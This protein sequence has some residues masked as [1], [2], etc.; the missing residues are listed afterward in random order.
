MSLDAFIEHLTNTH[1]LFDKSSYPENDNNRI[2]GLFDEE[3]ILGGFI[4]SLFPTLLIITFYMSQNKLNKIIIFFLVL[5]FCYI[6]IISGERSSFVK[7]LLLICGFI[8]FTSFFLAH[9]KKKLFF[10]YAQSL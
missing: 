3:Y 9:I 4:L 2:S 7:L 6:I 1:W 10:L 5:L 8:F